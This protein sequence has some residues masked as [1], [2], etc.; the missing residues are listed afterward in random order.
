MDGW[1]LPNPTARK[2]QMCQKK[3]DM[4]CKNTAF[5]GTHPVDVA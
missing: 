1:T 5:T 2:D 3:S 4:A